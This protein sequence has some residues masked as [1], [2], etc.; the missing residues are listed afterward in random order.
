MN[1][2]NIWNLFSIINI[3]IELSFFTPDR[4]LLKLN[5]SMILVV[6]VLGGR[7]TVTLWETVQRSQLIHET[8]HL[9]FISCIKLIFF[10]HT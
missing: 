8:K 1:A 7:M 3:L 9:V 10:T 5:Y 2:A 6:V 4:N